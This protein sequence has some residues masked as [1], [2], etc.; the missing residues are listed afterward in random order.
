MKTCPTCHE[1]HPDDVDS[2]PHD[3]SRLAQPQATRPAANSTPWLR[4][5]PEP[6][7]R[8][9]F[10]AIAVGFVFLVGLVLGGI[11]FVQHE[12]QQKILAEQA[13]RVRQAEQTRHAEQTE[14]DRQAEQARQAKQAEKDRQAEQ[15]SQAKKAQLQAEMDKLSVRCG[16]LSDKWDSDPRKGRPGTELSQE[17]FNEVMA[18]GDA[19]D[20]CWKR[21]KA[22]QDEINAPPALA[23]GTVTL[24][25]QQ[26]KAFNYRNI[27]SQYL[28]ATAGDQMY[29]CMVHG[30]NDPHS[31]VTVEGVPPLSA[32]DIDSCSDL[33]NRLNS[34]IKRFNRG[35]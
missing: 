26:S 34:A 20:D 10:V 29:E 21:V 18:E 14:K 1:S 19:K 31:Q 6:P 3:G 2:C 15:A 32:A 4:A 8:M 22:L 25:F 30:F 35:Y 23:P 9:R 12:K 13:E 24:D 16:E 5:K 7:S 17:E 28:G 33:Y 11:A 27:A